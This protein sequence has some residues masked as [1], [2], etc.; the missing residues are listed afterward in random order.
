MVPLL[1]QE[2]R[3][4]RSGTRSRGEVS[5]GTPAPKAIGVASEGPTDHS[6]GLRD[7]EMGHSKMKRIKASLM[8][9]IIIAIT[10]LIGSVWVATIIADIHG[11]SDGPEG[12]I[13]TLEMRD[14]APRRDPFEGR[15]EPGD[16]GAEGDRGGER[17]AN[18]PLEGRRPEGA[19]ASKHR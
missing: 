14:A 2:G 17:R 11:R 13:T 3:K 19:T 7:D 5:Q 10:V 6:T 18:G 1:Q 15:S 9:L 8:A 4:S 16:P 12:E